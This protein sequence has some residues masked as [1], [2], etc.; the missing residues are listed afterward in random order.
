MPARRRL[1]SR[2]DF[3]TSVKPSYF[4]AR[5]VRCNKWQRRSRDKSR[6]GMVNLNGEPAKDYDNPGFTGRCLNRIRTLDIL[7]VKSRGRNGV[8]SMDTCAC[9]RDAENAVDTKGV[10]PNGSPFANNHCSTRYEY[11]F[12]HTKHTHT[13]QAATDQETGHNH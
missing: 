6:F 13:N 9:G 1:K 4:P 12:R 3:L 11:S 2:K 5:V 8:T 7:A 10:Q